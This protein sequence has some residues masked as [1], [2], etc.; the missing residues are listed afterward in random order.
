MRIF[1][2]VGIRK[3]VEFQQQRYKNKTDGRFNAEAVAVL[4]AD[5]VMLPAIF[6]CEVSIP[7]ANYTSVQEY[8]YN[9]NVTLY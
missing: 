7:E 3:P 2:S 6:R 8:V 4:E 9:G 1:L 5:R